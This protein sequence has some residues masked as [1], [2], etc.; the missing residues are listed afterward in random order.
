M[1]QGNQKGDKTAEDSNDG[2]GR[3]KEEVEMEGVIYKFAI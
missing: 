2:E 1:G 3:K